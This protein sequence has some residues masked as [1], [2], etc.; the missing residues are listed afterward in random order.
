VQDGVLL[1]P[2]QVKVQI[3]MDSGT[4][5]GAEC[6]QYLSS[7][8]KRSGLEPGIPREQ[9]QDLVSAKLEV[10]HTR[11][12]IIPQN[13]AERL[14]WGFEGTHQGAKYWVFIDAG[15]GKAAD[16]LR[17]VQTPQGEAAL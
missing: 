6:T 12:C 16:I 17:V 15:S 8:T 5:V 11:L 4:V 3:S 13:G 2:D 14:C 7:H 9:A 1:Y 10:A